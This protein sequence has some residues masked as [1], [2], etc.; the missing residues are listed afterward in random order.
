MLRVVCVRNNLLLNAFAS[1]IFIHV[2]TIYTSCTNTYYIIY[3]HV[4]KLYVVH[5]YLIVC[6]QCVYFVHALRGQQF[7][8]ERLD[9]WYIH[10]YLYV[11]YMYCA[12]I[13]TCM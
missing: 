9:K 12:Q 2:Y 7:A 10:I 8:V 4:Y 6:I 13:F 5:N 11:Y 1:G 3:L